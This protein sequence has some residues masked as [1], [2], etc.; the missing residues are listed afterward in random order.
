MTKPKSRTGSSSWYALSVVLTDQTKLELLEVLEV[1]ANDL[2]A[3]RIASTVGCFLGGFLCMKRY[4][5]NPV[6]S[7]DVRRQVEALKK[8]TLA[9]LR[10]LIDH[11]ALGEDAR[12]MIDLRLESEIDLGTPSSTVRQAHEIANLLAACSATLRDLPF[13]ES[14]GTDGKTARRGLLRSLIRI[15]QESTRVPNEMRRARGAFVS[16]TRREKACAEFVRLAVDA[17]AADIEATLERASQDADFLRSCMLTK[18]ARRQAELDEH[19]AFLKKA[20]HDLRRLL[21]MQPNSFNKEL[22]WAS[23]S[24]HDGG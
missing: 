21:A 19:V 9:L 22:K 8:A 16:M 13:E 6:T 23:Q 17:L 5:D 7:T 4:A 15:H 3:D 20:V 10:L 14:R 12:T 18:D 11:T 2:E 1:P 24:D